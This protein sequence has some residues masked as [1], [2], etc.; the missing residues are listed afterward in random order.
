MTDTADHLPATD[1]LPQVGTQE[2][3]RDYLRAVW[4]RREFMVHM[5]L[6]LLRSQNRNTALGNFWLLLNPL[7]QVAVYFAI[8]GMILGTDRGVDNFLG[9]LTVG[10]FTFRYSQKALTE[11]AGVLQRNEGLIRS[12]Q[13]PRAVLPISTIIGQLIGF[14]SALFVILATS[15]LTGEYPTWRWLLLPGIV[16]LQT[17]FNLGAGLYL[18]RVGYRTRDTIELLPHFFRLVFYTSGVMFSV[19]AFVDDA[20]LRTVFDLNP[21]YD[22]V[23]LARWAIMGSDISALAAASALGW[24]VILLITGFFYFRAADHEY[25]R[26]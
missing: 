23:S 25:G 18:A 14:A 8:F 2:S 15:L 4:E 21:F 22:F 11:V 16:L 1:H 13:F 7:L 10:L 17:A 20:L 3:L 5:P 24:S 9:F 12:I 6:N 19:E 26:T